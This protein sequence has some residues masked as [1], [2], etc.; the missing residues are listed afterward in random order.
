M[1]RNDRKNITYSFYIKINAIKMYLSVI[2]KVYKHNLNRVIKIYK[3]V[4]KNKNIRC[5]VET[6][7]KIYRI[8]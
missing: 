7:Y 3:I 2:K 4:E 5:F 8:L 1:Q 6:I